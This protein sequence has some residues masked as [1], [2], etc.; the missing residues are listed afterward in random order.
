[1]GVQPAQVADL[2]ALKGDAI[3]NIPGAPGIG[4][5]GAQGPDRAV[6]I[7]RSGARARGRGGAQDVPREPAEQSRPIRMSK[8]LAT[9]RRDVPIEFSLEAVQGAGSRTWTLLKAVYKELEF[10]SLLQGTRARARTPARAIIACSATPEELRRVAGGD[11]RGRAGRGRDFQIRRK[12]NSRWTRS[13]SPGS[14]RG[15][16]HP[17]RDCSTR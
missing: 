13:G 3:D 6:R 11:S 2:L 10:H 17:V 12:A 5:K 9:I 8:R 1:M 4:D 16:R 14:R 7:G 15:A